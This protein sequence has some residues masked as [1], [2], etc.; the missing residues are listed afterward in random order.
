MEDFDNIGSRLASASDGGMAAK[1]TK[2]I[3]E[4]PSFT[5]TI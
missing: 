5:V 1:G 2:Q 4:M 3:H